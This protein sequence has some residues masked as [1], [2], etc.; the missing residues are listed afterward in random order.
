MRARMLDGMI[1]IPW[2]ECLDGWITTMGLVYMI[3]L[4]LHEL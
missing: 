3:F 4:L 2:E 1:R